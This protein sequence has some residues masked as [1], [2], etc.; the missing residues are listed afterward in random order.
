MNFFE[1]ETHNGISAV[2]YCNAHLINSPLV[3][4]KMGENFVVVHN[5]LAKNPLPTGFF[6]FGEEWIKDDNG[7]VSSIR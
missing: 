1:D 5:P 4:T 6:P 3:P 2:I 7:N